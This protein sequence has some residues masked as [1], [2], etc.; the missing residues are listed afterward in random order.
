MQILKTQVNLKE[1]GARFTMIPFNKPFNKPFIQPIM[2]TSIDAFG[3]LIKKE[4]GSNNFLHCIFSINPIV[5][6]IEK[7]LLKIINFKRDKHG[8][9]LPSE[10]NLIETQRMDP[11]RIATWCIFRENIFYIFE[12]L[13]NQCKA[14][15]VFIK[16]FYLNGKSEFYEIILAL[17]ENFFLILLRNFFLKIKL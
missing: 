17:L 10:S 5:I 11:L 4:F 14:D 16:S 6:F 7:P 9:L 13:N 1:G 2:Y 12:K 15:L 3:F 8:R